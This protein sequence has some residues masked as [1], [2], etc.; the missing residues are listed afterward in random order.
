[1]AV[2]KVI[3]ILALFSALAVTAGVAAAQPSTGGVKGQVTDPSAAAIPNATVTVTGA[4]SLVR[5]ARTDP[6]GQFTVPGL[7]PGKYTVRVDAKGFNSFEAQDLDVGNAPVVLN[8]PLAVAMETQSVTVSTDTNTVGTDP[9]Q[10]VGSLVLKGADLEAL[11]DDPDDLASD[12]QALAGPA[13][14]PNGGQIYIDGFTGGQLPP[15]SAIREVR[16]NSNPFSAEYDRLGFGRIEILTKPGSDKFRGQV[17]ANFGDKV[18][19]SRNPFVTGEV[20]D[21]SQQFF[22]GNVSGPL[23]K[24]ASFFVDVDRRLT[25]ENALIVAQIVDPN[26]NIIPYNNAVVTPIRRTDVSPRVDFQLTPNH[27]LSA[28]YRWSDSSSVGGVGGFNLPEL[29]SNSEGQT[30]TVQLTETAVLGTHA[31]NESRFQYFASRNNQN[32]N[33]TVPTITVQGSFVGGSSPYSLNFTNENHY[34]FQNNTTITKGTH[35]LR[36]G[37]R[38]RAVKQD[39]QSTS[40]FNGNYTFAGGRYPLLDASFNPVL[41]NGNPQLIPLTSI[42]L[43]RTT[44]LLMSKGLTGAQVQAL[45]YG[46][47]Q[48]TLNSGDPLAGVDQVDYGFFVQDDWRFRQ[49]L[50]ISAGLRYEAQTNI[51]DKSNIAPRLGLAWAPGARKGAQPKTVIRAGAGMFYDR[52]SEDLTLNAIRLNGI[53]QQQF[54]VFD[55][56]FYPNVPSPETLTNA[57]VPQAVREVS[58]D[59]RAP[60]IFQ[61]AIGVERQLPWHMTLAA[62]WTRSQGWN[63]LR[64]RNINAPYPA[65]GVDLTQPNTWPRPYGTDAGDIYL[66]ESSGMFKQNQ[67]MVNVQARISPK[68]SL[69]GFYVLGKADS[70]TD[71]AGSFPSNSYD[72]SLPSGGG[73]RLTCRH[74]AFIGGSITAPLAVTFNPFIIINSGGPFNITTGRD[75]NGDS[76][77]T[78]RPA[79]AT[80]LTRSSVLTT[81]Y[82]T[83]DVDPLPGATIVPRNYLQGPAFFSINMRMSRSWGFGEAKSSG[84]G[85]AGGFGGGGPRGGGGHGPG[86]GGGFMTMGR[87]MMGGRT[88]PP[89]NGM[90]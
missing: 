29:T 41:D 54:T 42:E 53:T 39:T 19:N 59:L 36:F 18:F 37:A 58:S 7:P 68:F 3:R 84:S 83:F 88:T 51:N 1:M 50:T 21:Y 60:R 32:A 9:S 72:L 24:K 80:D 8:V 26:F 28:R 31:I 57:L 64:S 16:I 87:G 56:T 12:L 81:A 22:G 49:N 77:F 76:I 38:I 71:G 33:S 86:G 82:G 89:A 4:N 10:S 47:N 44:Q 73:L 61:T 5:Q 70:N 65:E 20:P 25:D 63:Q 52:F 13:A 85:D 35:Q 6:Q 23:G 69:F 74:R 46:P 40:N 45:G 79:F 75:V 66:Y 34:E 15:K 62:N 17:F 43:Y 48:F 90:C 30:H 14:G 78:D 55:P 11:S 67:L 27:T 2:F